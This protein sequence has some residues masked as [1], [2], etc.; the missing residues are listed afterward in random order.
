MKK[1]VLAH[2][3]DMRVE[4]MW[5]SAAKG[6]PALKITNLTAEKLAT[7]PDAIETHTDE[8]T[9]AYAKRNFFPPIH[10]EFALP[11]MEED[12]KWDV[13]H[14]KDDDI[15]EVFELSITV[16]QTQTGFGKGKFW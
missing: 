8:F 13:Y 1:I 10:G 5:Q 6:N 15:V 12:G 3:I 9:W 11:A 2:T 7:N 16:E 4:E 14:A